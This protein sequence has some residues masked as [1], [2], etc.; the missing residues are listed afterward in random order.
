MADIII[1]NDQSPNTAHLVREAIESEIGR[2]RLA[3]NLSRKNLARFEKKYEVASQA[4]FLKGASEDLESGD[5]EYTEWM[6]EYEFS[7][8]LEEDIAALKGI[9]YVD[10]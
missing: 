6:G 1:K 10:S 4:F 9:Q 8:K 2:L 3:L 7:I 5:M